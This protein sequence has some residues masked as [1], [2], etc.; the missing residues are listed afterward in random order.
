[1]LKNLLWKIK[2]KGFFIELEP[3]NMFPNTLGF[4]FPNTYIMQ[5]A[6]EKYCMKNKIDLTYLR[7][8]N[9]IVISD[10]S[11]NSNMSNSWVNMNRT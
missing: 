3:E 7:K 6:I 9:P 8:E 2:R 4:I 1:M 11:T 5:V 10:T